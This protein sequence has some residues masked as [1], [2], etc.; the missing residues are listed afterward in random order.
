MSW[1]SP[2]HSVHSAP[3]F[4]SF[5]APRL[6]M[7]Y[8]NKALEIQIRRQTKSKQQPDQFLL[9]CFYTF[10]SKGNACI[11]RRW[12]EGNSL[13]KECLQ[14]CSLFLEGI[15]LQSGLMDRSWRKGGSNKWHLDGLFSGKG[16]LV[17]RSKQSWLATEI[18]FLSDKNHSPQSLT[19]QPWEM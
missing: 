12:Q 11:S 5:T 14:V 9:L 2:P 4:W 6:H 1:F 7:P 17:K 19:L 8:Y 16:Y 18:A 15:S 10:K 3:K 13:N